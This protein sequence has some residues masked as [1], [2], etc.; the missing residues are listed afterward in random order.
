[1]ALKDYAGVNVANTSQILKCLGSQ[2]DT[3]ADCPVANNT[4]KQFVVAVYNSQIRTNNGFIRILLPSNN[5]SAS[6]WD[7][8]AS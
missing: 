4:N 6:I 7:K 5:Y 1:L 8:N 2:N 3:V